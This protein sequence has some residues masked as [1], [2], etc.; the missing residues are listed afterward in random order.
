M[1][2]APTSTQAERERVYSAWNDE[3]W[4][5]DIRRRVQGMPSLQGV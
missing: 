3:Q 5:Y 4:R 1:E 2:S